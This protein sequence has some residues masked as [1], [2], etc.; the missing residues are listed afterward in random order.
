MK[1]FLSL[2]ICTRN[3]SSR[4]R[5][6]LSS[7]EGYLSSDIE[8]LVCDDSDDDLSQKVCADFAALPIIYF[9]GD[10]KGLDGAILKITK[11]A[12]GKYIWWIG[13]DILTHGAIDNVYNFLKNNP[14]L[15]FLWINS[16]DSSDLSLTAFKNAENDIFDDRNK[17]LSIGTIGLLGFI[18]STIFQRDQSLDSL[19]NAEKYLGSAFVC[20]YIIMFVLSK[21][22]KIGFFSEICFLS[23]TK[24]NEEKR[25]FNP[26]VV[27][28]INLPFIINSFKDVFSFNSFRSAISQNISQLL[29]AII[30]ERVTSRRNIFGYFPSLLPKF[31][32]I[33][34]S[35]PI[36]W[37][38][39][40]FLILPRFI[41]KIF[42]PFYILLRKFK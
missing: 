11:K 5:E 27:F 42:L 38:Y 26:S 41:L 3:Q 17:L 18:T 21:K 40:P 15:I 2:C 16:A 13:D 31:I 37:L 1:P 8:L 10:K 25:W 23:M 7:I 9:L 33:Y 6:T 32:Q 20:L 14:Q 28:G 29:K 22:G 36:F 24:K 34:W 19:K 39:M 4:L 30:L 35:Y 12:T